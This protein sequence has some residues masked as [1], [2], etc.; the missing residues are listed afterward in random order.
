MM[1]HI[2]T[3]KRY[4]PLVSVTLAT[5]N[6]DEYLKQS[7]DC[8]I[9]QSLKEIE[10]ICIDDGSSDKTLE[11]LTEF[12]N[13]DDRINVISKPINE[14]LAAARNESLKLA[15]GKY[16]IFVDG[17]DLMDLNLIKKAYELAEFEKSDIVIWDYL[18]FETIEE[19]DKKR[20]QS[21][22]LSKQL[23]MD[24]VGLLKRPAFT[25]IKLIK[26]DIAKTMDI[27]FPYGLTRQD[28]PVHWH[29]MTQVK[30]I[31]ILPEF[32][33][34]YRQQPNATTHRSDK[35][36]FDLSTVMKIVYK[37]LKANDLYSEY[38]ETYLEM[39]LNFL[40]GMYD[41]A[42]KLIKL[43]A[44]NIVKNSLGNDQIQ[45]ILSN[46]PLRWQARVFYKGLNGSF[47][48]KIEFIAWKLI[49]NIYRLIKK[50]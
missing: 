33:S 8:I 28:I 31:S 22:G 34:F 18:S 23:A 20:V 36:L 9:N 41:K 12:A 16:V 7:L 11:I 42:D 46:M 49:R 10:I 5:Y 43:E 25:W 45:Y 1:E 15:K 4:T 50:N 44:L 17:D 38:K 32:L 39:Q 19:L 29:L 6:V 2:A 21:S 26:T 13:K 14:G 35:R 24:K 27:E 30:K 40:F 48:A 3:H 47:I 37:Y